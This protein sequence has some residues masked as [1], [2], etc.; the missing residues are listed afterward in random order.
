MVYRPL[1]GPVTAGRP[2][3]SIVRLRPFTRKLGQASVE[4]GLFLEQC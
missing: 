4:M 1:R 3:R 2:E